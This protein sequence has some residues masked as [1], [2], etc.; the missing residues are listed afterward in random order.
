MLCIHQQVNGMRGDDPVN[1]QA[2]VVKD[3]L[4]WVHGQARPRA[5]IDIFV[6]QILPRLVE[7]RP[8]QQPMDPVKVE[9]PP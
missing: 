9:Q 5:N 1:Q 7:R 2:T 6:M 3:M 4:N 8:M